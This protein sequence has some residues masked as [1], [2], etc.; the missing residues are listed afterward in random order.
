MSTR[1]IRISADSQQLFRDAATEFARI[2]NEAVKQRGRFTVALSGRI[3][4]SK[5]VFP[6]GERFPIPSSLG[7]KSILLGR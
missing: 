5:P 1:E 2:A 4:S 3:H 7:T 6:L